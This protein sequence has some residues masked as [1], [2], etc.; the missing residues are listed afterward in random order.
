VQSF[1][2]SGSSNQVTLVLKDIVNPLSSAKTPPVLIE[3]DCI[4]GASTNWAKLYTSTEV[5]ESLT[6]T[7]NTGSI[8]VSEFQNISSTKTFDLSVYRISFTLTSKVPPSG[9]IVLTFPSDF[10]FASMVEPNHFSCEFTAGLITSKTSCQFYS[11]NN[12]VL[13]G[14]GSL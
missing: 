7:A 1:Y 14:L 3:V 5:S 13:V 4:T 2:K 10:L 12:T 9:F 11:N 8:L 6:I